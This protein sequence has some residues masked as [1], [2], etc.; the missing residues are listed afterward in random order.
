MSDRIITH[1]YIDPISH[2]ETKIIDFISYLNDNTNTH[3]PS[4]T[5]KEIKMNVLEKGWIVQSLTTQRNALIRARN[6]EMQG[7]E[8]HTLRTKEIEFLNTL[9]HKYEGENVDATAQPETNQQTQ[10]RK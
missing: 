8:I 9:I 5:T 6:K 4:E 7:S 3:S 10:Q 1:K 2:S